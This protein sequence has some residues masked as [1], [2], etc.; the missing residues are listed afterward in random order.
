MKPA[1]LSVMVILM[2]SGVLSQEP[3][4]DPKRQVV[5][6][7]QVQKL[8]GFFALKFIDRTTRMPE[9]VFDASKIHTLGATT[10]IHRVLWEGGDSL[11]DFQC[12]VRDGEEIYRYGFKFTLSPPYDG[13]PNATFEDAFNE[14]SLTQYYIWR[15]DDSFE[16]AWKAEIE[17]ILIETNTDETEQ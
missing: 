17:D 14:R 10:G 13:T 4:N 12:Y 1:F 5:K 2:I 8:I 9:S 16:P 15:I 6:L 7:E 11:H 3:E